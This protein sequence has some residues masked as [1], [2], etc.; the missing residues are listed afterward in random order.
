VE[1]GYEEP[2]PTPTKGVALK[3]LKDNRKKDKKALYYL[4]QAVDESAF[5]KIAGAETSKEAWKILEKVFK[6][7]DRV[8]QVWLQTLR[9]ELEAMKMKESEGVSE[10]ISRVQS[11][12]NKLKGNGET[13]TDTRIVEKILRSL[14]ENFENVVCAI[15]ESKDLDEM[16][17]DEL[18]GSLEAHEQRK[19]RKEMESLEEVL[20]VKATIKEDKAMY[21]ENNRGRGRG[22]GGRGFGRNG[23]RNKGRCYNSEEKYQPSQQN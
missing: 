10:Y 14:T 7:A 12:A 23:G 9:G 4:Y 13:L 18:A 6:G 8:K 2:D 21:V 20:Q 22:R 17:V 16:T 11:V 5:E 19:K 1:T 15:E 3:S